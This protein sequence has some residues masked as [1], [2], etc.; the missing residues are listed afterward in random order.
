MADDLQLCGSHLGCEETALCFYPATSLKAKFQSCTIV[1]R[2]ARREE[3]CPSSSKSSSNTA[4][5]QQ[6]LLGGTDSSAWPGA[7]LAAELSDSESTAV[8]TDSSLESRA[9]APDS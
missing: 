6:Q 7:E 2:E 1:L 4:K 5:S 9:V 3:C 8:A